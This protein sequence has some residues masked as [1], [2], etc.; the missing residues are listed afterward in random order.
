VDAFYE[1]ISH[2][3]LSDIEVDWGEMVVGEV[4]PA[5]IPDLW[6]GRPVVVTGRLKGEVGERIAVHGR[7][8]GERRRFEVPVRTDGEQERP[9]IAQVWAR[10]KIMEL[11]DRSLWSSDKAELT[12]RIRRLALK[13]GLMSKFTAFVAVDSS[14]VTAGEAGYTVAQPVPVPHG[15]KYETTVP[16]GE[17]A[18]N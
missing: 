9:A 2:P 6:Q 18:N 15:V 5:R 13:Y 17:T 8:G 4:Y 1:R 16:E 7:V 11:A 12:D 14:R 10:M 3:A